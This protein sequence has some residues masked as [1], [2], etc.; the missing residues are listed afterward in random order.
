MLLS[1]QTITAQK[2]FTRSG[3]TTFKAS[4][5]AFEPIEAVNK[6]TS[7]ILTDSGEVAALLLVKGFHFKVALMQ[8]HFNENYMDSDTYPKATFKGNLNQFSFDKMSSKTKFKLT[9]SLNI[10]GVSKEITTEAVVIKKGEKIIFTS[11]FKVTPKDFK[12]TIPSI[13]SKKIAKSITIKIHYELIK[14]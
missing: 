10:K 11:E 3:N 1:I 7:A 4:V 5:E 6:S 9:G 14:K 2:Y 12:I 8:E 13:V